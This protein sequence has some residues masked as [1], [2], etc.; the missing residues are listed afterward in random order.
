MLLDALLGRRAAAAY[1]RM[2]PCH[3]FSARSPPHEYWP[4]HARH[5]ERDIDEFIRGDGISARP[6]AVLAFRVALP[7][8]SFSPAATKCR[9]LASLESMLLISLFPESI[10]FAARRARRAIYVM[11][12][13][14]QGGGRYAALLYF[15][16]YAAARRRSF[17]VSLLGALPEMGDFEVIATARILSIIFNA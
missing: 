11:G 3:C 5:A 9:Q 12:H 16:I 1:F 17:S 7:T 15:D 8:K 14:S 2:P 4:A 10:M 13:I 6:R